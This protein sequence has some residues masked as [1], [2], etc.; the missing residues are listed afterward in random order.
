MNSIPRR[1]FGKNTAICFTG[2]HTFHYP[3]HGLHYPGMDFNL[4]K[5]NKIAKKIVDEAD[6]SLGFKISDVLF[7][8]SNEKVVLASHA[9]PAILLHSIIMLE[10]AKHEYEFNDV[11]DAGYEVAM[12]HSVGEYT[13]LVATGA[14]PL[15]EG[16]QLVHKRGLAMQ[17]TMGKNIDINENKYGMYALMFTT[18][19]RALDLCETINAGNRAKC[20]VANHN[21]EQQVV[22]SGHMDAMDQVISLGKKRKQIRRAIKLDIPTPLHSCYM[23][24]A[25]IELEEALNN[26]HFDDPIIPIISN[27]TG[28]IYHTS[29]NIKQNLL[30]QLHSTVKWSNSMYKCGE[31]QSINAFHEFGPKRILVRLLKSHFSNYDNIYTFDSFCTIADIKQQALPPQ[32]FALLSKYERCDKVFFTNEIRR[33]DPYASIES[34]YIVLFKTRNQLYTT[35]EKFNKKMRKEGIEIRMLPGHDK[36]T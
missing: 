3:G 11:K 15:R 26:I 17:H 33:L 25:I 29:D 27:V 23:K 6:A 19:E 7:G 13:A 35:V 28:E 9:Q 5:N 2:Q 14:I 4:Y 8:K 21:E 31:M 32:F 16:L 24:P 22:I 20:S 1:L 30:D 12:G 36:L 18:Y 10:I 34:D